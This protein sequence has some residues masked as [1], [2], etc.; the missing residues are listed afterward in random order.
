[1]SGTQGPTSPRRYQAVDFHRLTNRRAASPILTQDLDAAGEFPA[2][3]TPNRGLS[4]PSADK[5][6]ILS[7]RSAPCGSHCGSEQP[8]CG[9]IGQGTCS[10]VKEEG[11]GKLKYIYNSS[12]SP[13]LERHANQRI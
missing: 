3:Q 11:R 12:C 8:L 7:G 4:T 9:K 5:R 13:P 6:P 1:M 10:S 2:E